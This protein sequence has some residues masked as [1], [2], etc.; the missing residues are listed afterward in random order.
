MFAHKFRT[1][2][3]NSPS[4]KRTYANG[5][6]LTNT[7]SHLFFIAVENRDSKWNILSRLID[8][9]AIDNSLES[10]KHALLWISID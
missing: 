10:N 5:V 9:G 2:I 1:A 7:K 8:V 6:D 4:V 3:N